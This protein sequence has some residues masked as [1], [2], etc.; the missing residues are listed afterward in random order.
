LFAELVRAHRRRLG[1]TQDELAARAGIG[2]RSVRAIEGGRVRSPRP[3]TV[4]L[5][6]DALELERTDRERFCRA[7]AGSAGAT[8]SAGPIVPA[9]LPLDVPGFTGR[10]A[11]LAELDGMLAHSN[12]QGT[13]VIISAVSGT[14]GI[15][16]TTLAVHWAHRVADKFPDGQLYANL[17][18]FD[19]SG[20]V[21]APS[22]AIRR[23][24]DALG[25]PAGRVPTDPEAQVGLYRSLLANKRMLVVLD[26]AR[27]ADQVRPL[28][29]GTPTAFVVVTSRNRL[30]GLVAVEGAHPLT[31]GL[32]STVESREL[33]ASRL[34]PRRVAAE[35]DAVERIIASCARLPLALAIAAARAQ[36]AGLRLAAL[37]VEVADPDAGRRLDSLDAGEPASQ[38]RAVFSSSYAALRPPTARLFRLLGLHPGPD[39]SVA[40]VA[41]L[42]GTRP[43]EAQRQLA[44]L[45]RAS[46][47]TERAPG[48]YAF[49]DLLRV[50]A[51][52][53]ARGMDPESTRLA[54][55]TRLLDHYAYT[56]H[57]GDRLLNPHRDPILLPPTRP[58]CPEE[59]GNAE[60]ATDWFAA[61]LPVLRAAI[62]FAAANGYDTHAWQL[63]WSVDTFLAHHGYWGEVGTVWDTAAQA[64]RRLGD[65]NAEAY[66]H[67]IGSQP[68]ARFGRYEQAHSQ[69]QLALDLYTR[70][71]N[72]VALAHTHRDLTVLYW[73]QTD[74]PNALEHAKLALGIYQQAEHPRGIASAHNAVGWCHAELGNHAE[75]LSHCEQALSQYQRLDDHEGQAH[76]W[77]S[78]G[79]AH[80][81]LGHHAEAI[82]CYRRA[83]DLDR[84]LGDWH[85]MA[86]SLTHLGD[87]YQA[88]GDLDAARSTWQQA[89]DAFADA[90]HPDAEALR[91][92]LDALGPARPGR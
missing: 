5:L 13:A 71:G 10:V 57:A 46:L 92:K 37:A 64:A 15:G 21:V 7:A 26:N 38:L 39:F 63:A 90:D 68:H 14:A 74:L 60:K 77:D 36:H 47:L 72:L 31:L 70:A 9:H 52:E 61:E 67:R 49:H 88:V 75:A 59:P 81:R 82:D 69:A 91:G 50:Y 6:A 29:P 73:R 8:A 27:D 87:T 65:V 33:L 80:D 23:F 62:G 79:Y 41:N 2:V 20:Q 24:L 17:R 28:L 11:E 16:K 58:E 44:D 89:L 86:E 85:S 84:E 78:L 18:G 40:A 48:R 1:L 55:L 32:L 51:A 45:V 25:V 30:T 4:R 43:A 56:A 42:A 35:P 83:I 3:G 66:A 22:D 34:G 12:E 54:A 19:P 76:A 53:L